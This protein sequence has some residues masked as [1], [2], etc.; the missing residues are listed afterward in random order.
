MVSLSNPVLA[1]KANT[2]PTI[3]SQDSLTP[4]PETAYI[5]RTSLLTASAA[6][7]GAAL[8]GAAPAYFQGS[9]NP[10]EGDK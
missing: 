7:R 10:K 9:P 1:M 8:S 2:A 6:G 3:S 5:P 4:A